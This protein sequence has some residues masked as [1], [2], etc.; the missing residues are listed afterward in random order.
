MEVLILTTFVSVCLAAAGAA[1]FVWSVKNRTF[2]QSDRLAL[3]PLEEP[4]PLPP[5]GE[6]SL[7]GD[8]SNQTESQPK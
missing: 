2:D 5:A 4:P 6:P 7:T 1:L 8:R 3:L